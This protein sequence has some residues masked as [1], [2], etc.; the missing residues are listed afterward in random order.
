MIDFYRR[1]APQLRTTIVFNGDT[2]PCVSYEGTR[3]AI[4]QVPC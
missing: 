1:I 4:K 2:D 3:T